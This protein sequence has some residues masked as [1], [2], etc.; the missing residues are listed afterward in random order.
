M[1]ELTVAAIVA[2]KRCPPISPELSSAFEHLHGKC[3]I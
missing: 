2:F 1:N 3:A